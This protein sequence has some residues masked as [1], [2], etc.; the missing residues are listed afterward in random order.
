MGAPSGAN[1]GERNERKRKTTNIRFTPKAQERFRELT[2]KHPSLN[3]KIVS[4]MRWD[5]DGTIT[6]SAD[7]GERDFFFAAVRKDGGHGMC[8]GI[9]FHRNYRKDADGNTI[10]DT[11]GRA[12]LSHEDDGEYS[13]HT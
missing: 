4:L 8:G 12:I 7:F 9:V 10:R 11:D 13:I 3:E 1:S 5:G 6:I 2:W